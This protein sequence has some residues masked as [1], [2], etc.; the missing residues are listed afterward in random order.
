M[1]AGEKLA[2]TDFSKKIEGKEGDRHFRVEMDGVEE[3]GRAKR[4]KSP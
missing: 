2:V 4:I 3:D 1:A